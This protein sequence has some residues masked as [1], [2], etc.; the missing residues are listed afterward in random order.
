MEK[1]I[2]MFIKLKLIL[3]DIDK[4]KLCNTITE[5]NELHKLL[6]SEYKDKG[7]KFKDVNGIYK[8]IKDFKF[9]SR[10]INILFLTVLGN[11]K[12]GINEINYLPVNYNIVSI[13]GINKLSILTL[14]GRVMCEYKFIEYVEGGINKLE[15]IDGEYCLFLNSLPS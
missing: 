4:E 3:S 15:L 2:F 13:K 1:K 5:F 11:I 14:A 7:L 8:E 6:F 10:L 9:P 12:K